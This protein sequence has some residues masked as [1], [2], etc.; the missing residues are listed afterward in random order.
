[1]MTQSDQ[2]LNLLVL[3]L[4][5]LGIGRVEIRE[6]ELAGLAHNDSHPHLVVAQSPF[7]V[8]C[9]RSWGRQ[10]GVSLSGRVFRD[11]ASLRSLRDGFAS[12]YHLTQGGRCP[13][14]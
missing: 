13:R 7:E 6:A 5:C 12:L 11:S 14:T 8:D 1:M 10:Q 2:M 4:Q 3:R 9:T